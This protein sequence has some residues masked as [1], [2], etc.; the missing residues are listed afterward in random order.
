M[1]NLRG[2]FLMT[3]AMAGFALEDMFIKKL[4]DSLP[5]GQ[6]LILLGGGGTI[7][8]SLMAMRRG[9]RILSRDLLRPPVMLRNLAELGTAICFISALSLI[10]IST[11]SAVIQATPLAVTLGAAVFFRAEVGWR[12]WSAIAVGLIGV[13]MIIRPGLDGFQPASLL[14]VGAVIGLATRD[15][16]VRAIPRSVSSLQLSAYGFAALVPA[17]IV[18]LGFG[19]SPQ[20]ID[21]SGA[22]LLA[23]ALMMGVAGYYAVVE[24]TRV[25]DVAAVTPFRYARLLFALIIGVAI[26]GERPD[27]WT[28]LGAAI[29]IGSGL[30]TFA[31]ERAL[32][33]RLRGG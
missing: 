10:P 16:A 5:V 11:A 3:A 14:A 8:F 19:P 27:H 30:Y 20:P 13:L 22:T 1:D 21:L 31:R 18:L 7:A 23:G 29:I 17:G 2:I 15:L 25:G 6:I 26:F 4:S 28:L 33:S 9:Q 32:S 12:R 24:A